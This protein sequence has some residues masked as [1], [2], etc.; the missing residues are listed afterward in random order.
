MVQFQILLD[1]KQVGKTFLYN[2]E[3]AAALG[4]WIMKPGN[5]EEFPVKGISTDGLKSFDQRLRDYAI[6]ECCG[7]ALSFTVSTCCE[8]LHVRPI[9]LASHPSAHLA[10]AGRGDCKALP[11]FRMGLPVLHSLSENVP[12]PPSKS[13]IYF[14]SCCEFTPFRRRC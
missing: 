13:H 4:A 6:N 11:I 3:E 8:H 2:L 12:R 10:I 9:P 1:D 7:P 5:W 14:A